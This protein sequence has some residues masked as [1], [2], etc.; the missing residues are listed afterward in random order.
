MSAW[1]PDNLVSTSWC[2][3]T[4]IY[5]VLKANSLIL[6]RRG[7]L[8]S[9]C[10]LWFRTGWSIFWPVRCFYIA[11][12]VT[13]TP[14]ERYFWRRASTPLSILMTITGWASTNGLHPV[15]VIIDFTPSVEKRT[16]T[17]KGQK[18][19]PCTAK[20]WIHLMAWSATISTAGLSITERRTWD[21]QLACRTVGTWASL[22]GQVT[23]NIRE[24]HF[25]KVRKSGL[26]Q[27]VLTADRFFLAYSKT[28]SKPQR[29]T[30][31]R[32][33]NTSESLPNS[34]SRNNHE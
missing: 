22:Q 33:R 9:F 19:F 29:R 16:Q 10:H 20:W 30:T 2:P 7:S 17:V 12:C 31:K 15:D 25:E 26:L 8:R 27:Y 32:P 24:L 28:R 18:W 34:I 21:R 4:L 1:S 14:S 5:V 6:R 23:L 11:G 3:D 13:A